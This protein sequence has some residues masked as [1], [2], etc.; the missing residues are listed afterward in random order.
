MRSW[1]SY[2]SGCNHDRTRHPVRLGRAS[3]QLISNQDA[4]FEGQVINAMCKLFVNRKLRNSIHQPL[5]NEQAKCTSRTL[6]RFLEEFLRS[7]IVVVGM[8]SSLTFW[9]CFGAVWNLFTNKT[10]FFL[11]WGR[12]RRLLSDGC[13]PSLRNVSIP[14][15]NLIWTVG[16]TIQKHI[17]MRVYMLGP[18]DSETKLYFDLP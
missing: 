6:K 4:N 10:H 3:L 7:Q 17:I 5:G 12:E 16:K 2:W 1:L 9:W 15:R 14:T 8:G 13:Y 18:R 11:I